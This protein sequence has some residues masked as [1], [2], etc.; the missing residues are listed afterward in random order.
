MRRKHAELAADAIAEWPVTGDKQQPSDY[1]EYRVCLATPMFG[2]GVE[3]GRIDQ[4]MP[5]RAAAIRGQLRFWWRHACAEET[6]PELFERERRLWGGIGTTG[7]VASQ[8]RVQVLGDPV[9]A[10]ALVSTATLSAEQRYAWGPAVSDGDRDLLDSGYAFALRLSCPPGCA[11]EVMTALRWWASFGGLGARVRRGL[12]AVLVDGL[13]PVSEDEVRARGGMLKLAG[14]GG[15]KPDAAWKS[16]VRKLF[17]F[18][19]GRGIGRRRGTQRPGRTY[20]PEADQIRRF[21]N[22][23]ANGNHP[24]DHQAANVFPRAAF[25]MPILFEFKGAGEPPTLELLPAGDADRLASPLVLRPYWNGKQWQAAAL[26]L[27]GW[28][29]ALELGLRFRGAHHQPG[30]WPENPAQQRRAAMTIDPMVR[31]QQ[32]RADDPLSAFMDFFERG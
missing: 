30:H 7:P 10:D 24:P 2:G 15:P 16:A 23:D 9:G 4:S 3:P 25:G 21:T 13:D 32:P 27:P 26:L 14:Q 5:V 1:K 19:Q 6:G 18:R 11:A 20:W 31:G 12:G 8:V 28:R 17:D 29:Q 22:R